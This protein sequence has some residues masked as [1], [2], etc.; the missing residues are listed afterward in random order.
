M[1]KRHKGAKKHNKNH[2]SKWRRG[3]WNRLLKAIKKKPE[4][5]KEAELQWN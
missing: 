3:K 2:Q 1:T 5:T 4:N